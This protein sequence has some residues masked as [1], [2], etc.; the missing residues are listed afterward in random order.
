MRAAGLAP[1]PAV[2]VD[3]IVGAHAESMREALTRGTD[4]GWQPTALFC[5]N[6]LL[7]LG[8]MRALRQTGM[9]ILKT[10]PYWVSTGWCSAS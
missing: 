1:W 6:D 8:V 10:Y 3:F 9:R 4:S 2:E 5:S 7:A